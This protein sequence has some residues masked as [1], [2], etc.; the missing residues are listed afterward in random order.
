MGDSSQPQPQVAPLD[1]A[2]AQ[3]AATA[4]QRPPQQ[5]P[6]PSTTRKD[7]HFHKHKRSNS[8]GYL[9]SSI[10]M[11]SGNTNNSNGRRH[12]HVA[13]HPKT[14]PMVRSTITQPHEQKLASATNTTPASATTAGT[15][16]AN[17]TTK[18]ERR[19]KTSGEQRKRRPRFTCGDQNDEIQK[20][21][22]SDLQTHALVAGKGIEVEKRDSGH[23]ACPSYRSP[24]HKRGPFPTSPTRYSPHQEPDLRLHQD[25][26]ITEA[27]A[28]GRDS[29]AVRSEQGNLDIEHGPNSKSIPNSYQRLGPDR[30]QLS[31][32]EMQSKPEIAVIRLTAPDDM[33]ATLTPA[34]PSTAKNPTAA[35]MRTSE[36]VPPSNSEITVSQAKLTSLAFENAEQQ[37]KETQQEDR[38]S[39]DTADTGEQTQE[40]LDMTTKLGQSNVPALVVRSPS[41]ISPS[42]I[43]EQNQIHPPQQQHSPTQKTGAAVTPPQHHHYGYL[44]RLL[45]PSPSTKSLTSLTKVT[46]DPVKAFATPHPMNNNQVDHS[47]SYSRSNYDKDALPV[48]Q[49]YPNQQSTISSVS[50]AVDLVSKLHNS[51]TL[52]RSR[53]HSS[54]HSMF[55]AAISGSPSDS[56]MT[57]HRGHHLRHG[58]GASVKFNSDASSRYNLGF[59]TSSPRESDANPYLISRFITPTSQYQE[60]L[61][62][63]V[64]KQQ[65]QQQQQA[66]SS[67]GRHP[68]GGPVA[69]R[70]RLPASLRMTTDVKPSVPPMHDAS[71]VV[72]TSTTPSFSNSPVSS[73]TSSPGNSPI[74]IHTPQHGNSTSS[75]LSAHGTTSILHSTAISSPWNPAESMS[76]TQLKLLLQRD[77]SHDDMDEQDMARRDKMH[78]EM[79]RIQR[80]YK[81]VCMYSDPVME[82]LTRCLARK[83]YWQSNT[84]GSS[85]EEQNYQT[86]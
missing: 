67:I 19:T 3:P 53:S 66:G 77:S 32:E 23:N 50:S 42:S 46:S 27:G 47:T 21:Q 33:I 57:H 76:R 55:T 36:T 63:S 41:T 56:A 16:A 72:S 8:Q 2:T 62:T 74:Q 35:T 81:C 13:I 22:G 15:N 4:T 78:K 45:S 44:T 28:R 34:L 6:P 51:S 5:Q 10:N 54:L 7:T 18:P 65:Q 70:R 71:S 31:F 79:E 1:S 58:S 20:P 29:H 26:Q 75:A 17:T 9:V 52:G 85:A 40:R 84:L 86:I 69:T 59:M 73:T 39:K 24:S 25:L 82:S 80:E 37:K 60:A 48:Q 43:A 83:R 11:I 68:T 61:S 64:T 38:V 30:E 12:S 14:R 49:D